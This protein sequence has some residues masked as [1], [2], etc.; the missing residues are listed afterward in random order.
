MVIAYSLS[1]HFCYYDKALSKYVIMWLY[2]NIKVMDQ[3]QGF[4]YWDS[5]AGDSVIT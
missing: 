1:L 5:V 2:E 3:F 4:L